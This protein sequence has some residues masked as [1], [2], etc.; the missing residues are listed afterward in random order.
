[1]KKS[2]FVFFIL[3]FLFEFSVFSQ[4]TKQDALVL[5]HNGNY[6]KTFESSEIKAP[7]LGI[8]CN[9]TSTESGYLLFN[10]LIFRKVTTND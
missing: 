9:S 5:Y 10:N 8:V 2:F 3:F 4:T 7:V 6:K 1:M